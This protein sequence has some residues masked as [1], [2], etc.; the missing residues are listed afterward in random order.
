MNIK[1]I[2]RN[3]NRLLSVFLAFLLM[4]ALVPAVS[5]VG[6]IKAYAVGDS[7]SSI[8][9]GGNHSA[10]IKSDGSLWLWG[11][12]NYGQIGDGTTVYRQ[13]PVKVM[14]DVV[15]VS[16]GGWHTLA[17]KSDGSLWAWGDN[18][19]GQIGNGFTINRTSPV[20]IMDGVI[21]ISAGGSFSM[22]IKSDGSLWAW[23]DNYYGQSGDGTKLEHL[24]PI[25][26][27]N[28]VIKISLG[29]DF[30][31]AIKSDGS[32][33]AWGDNSTGQLGDNTT[34]NKLTPVKIMDN[35]MQV[36]AGQ[37]HTAAVKTDGSLW[38]WG[39]NS[40]GQLGTGRVNSYSPTPYKLMD[41]VVQASAGGLHTVAI[42]SDGSL[43]AWGDN[44][45]GQFGDGTFAPQSAPVKI[46]NISTRIIQ[47]SAGYAS[48]IAVEFDSISAGTLWSWGYDRQGNTGYGNGVYTQKPISGEITGDVM[49]F[50]KSLSNSVYIYDSSINS[51]TEGK[52]EEKFTDISKKPQEMQNAIHFLESKNIIKGESDNLFAPDKPVTQAEVAAF[53][54]RLLEY[55][56]IS[57][58]LNNAKLDYFTDVKKSDW[59]YNEAYKADQFN[60]INGTSSTSFAP[61]AEMSREVIFDIATHI[62]T[63]YANCK[64]PDGGESIDYIRGF[65]DGYEFLFAASTEESRAEIAFPIKEGLILKRIDN[66]L[67]FDETMTR[68]DFAI[69]LYRM[70]EKFEG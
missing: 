16:A 32:L 21:Q 40:L 9:A 5:S 67:A 58:D 46:K 57:M 44:S 26:I 17:L 7:F 33:W 11:W 62:L 51:D 45:D 30:S 1:K 14:D 38:I 4:L 31:M 18:D 6:S 8:S 24:T 34:V 12:N 28:N 10:F 29:A 22:A 68:G 52:Y 47:I 27:M 25:K 41:N 39:D 43:W 49:L 60:I 42:K 48:T 37:W 36:S 56:G 66:R 13:Q 55:F 64:F 65:A 15:Q 59:F 53:T 69:L 23:G 20:K 3:K 54:V 61:N 70:F 35:V 63:T 2:L 50:A 19:K